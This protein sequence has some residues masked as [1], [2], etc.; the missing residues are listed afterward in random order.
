MD[1]EK[2]CSSCLR[3]L[4]LDAFAAHGKTKDGRRNIC[5]ACAEASK[6]KKN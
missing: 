2:V 1:N 3:S 5:K 6:E 4:P